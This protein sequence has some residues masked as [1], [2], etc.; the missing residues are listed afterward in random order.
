[1]ITQNI[2]AP[3]SN[4]S[5]SPKAAY[6]AAFLNA[7]G[8][9]LHDVFIYPTP[10]SSHAEPAYLIEV[11]KAEVKNLLRH[12]RKY[13][14]RAKI[15]LRALEEGERSVWASW[16]ERR[17]L[18]EEEQD[19]GK[20]FPISCEDKRAPGFGY[21]TVADGDFE[22]REQFLPGAEVSQQVYNL[23]RMFH[24]VPEGQ[25]E[26]PNASALPMDSNM[27]VMNGID[28]HKGCY[29]GQELTIRTHH[30]GVVRKRV[31]P[32]Q[33]YDFDDP[34]PESDVLAYDDGTEV[35][36]PPA[37]ASISKVSPRK[38]PSPGKFLSGIGNIGLALCRIE[39]MTDLAFTGEATRYNPDEEFSVSWDADPDGTYEAGRVKVK[40]I[41]PPWT[42]EY[43]LRGGARHRTPMGEAQRAKEAV[44]DLQG[45]IEQVE[46][47]ER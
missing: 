22:G 27:D 19:E 15:K 21:R 1:M 10:D 17:S 43:I 24:G 16:D 26:I 8:R 41:I 2:A 11:D 18:T 40:A 28:F 25:I 34:R 13:K 20:E 7:Q 6:Y 23:R 39:T 42:R 30:R 37:G 5:S 46:Q 29:L 14:L 35:P 44:E 9:V 12:L 3:E 47:S 38:S 32:V 45:K 4:A 33:I 31:L 36:L